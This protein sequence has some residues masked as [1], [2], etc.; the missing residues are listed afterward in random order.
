MN[1]SIQFRTKYAGDL[2][3]IGKVLGTEFSKVAPNLPVGYSIFHLADMGD[4]FVVAGRPGCSQPREVQDMKNSC[5]YD[6]GQTRDSLKEISE[7][8]VFIAIERQL[9]VSGWRAPTQRG[10][11]WYGS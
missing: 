10:T 6:L 9:S 8:G 2:D 3:G 1:I 7:K 4:P 11:C 5:L